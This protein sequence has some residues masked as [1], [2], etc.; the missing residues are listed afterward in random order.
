LS[1]YKFLVPLYI[2]VYDRI[3]WHIALYDYVH[4]VQCT[5]IYRILYT[6]N[7]GATCIFLLNLLRS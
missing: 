6:Y 1:F 5:V 4:I 3:I 7:V 2:I